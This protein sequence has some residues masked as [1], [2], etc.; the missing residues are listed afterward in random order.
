MKYTVAQQESNPQMISI[1]N[2]EPVVVLCFEVNL[3]ERRG[4]MTLCIPVDLVR[5]LIEG[6]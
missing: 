2:N 3:I 1:K 6:E 5:T 4:S